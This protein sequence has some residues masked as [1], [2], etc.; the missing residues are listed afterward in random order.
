MPTQ[1]TIA[2]KKQH[3]TN[4]FVPQYVWRATECRK[5]Q[6][7]KMW[8]TFGQSG[9]Y[10]CTDALSSLRDFREG[11]IDGGDVSDDRLLIWRRNINIC[12]QKT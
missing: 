1:L 11:I 9:T 6:K 7:R 5:N 4:D 8:E 3:A 12:G 2:P 10:I